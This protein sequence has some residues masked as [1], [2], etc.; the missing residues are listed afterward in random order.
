MNWRSKGGKSH[1]IKM[2][3]EEHK[4]SKR[5]AEKAVNAVF[6]RMTAALR[7][8][9][10]VELPVGWFWVESRAA[11]RKAAGV[12]KFRNIADGESFS[13]LVRYPERVIRYR[14]KP[15]LIQTGPFTSP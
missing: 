10:E 13:R 9:E 3:I 14:P 15:E 11:G 1:L 12:Q 8:G 4:L 7:R 6:E 2:L 5:K